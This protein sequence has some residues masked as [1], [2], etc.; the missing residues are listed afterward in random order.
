MMTDNAMMVTAITAQ[1]NSKG[2][3]SIFV[4]SKYSFSL[5]ES[6]LLE[7]KLAIGLELDEARLKELR[8]LSADDKTYG[9]AVRYAALRPRSEWEIQQYLQRKKAGPELCEKILNKLRK[10]DFVNDKVFASR[11]IENRRQLKPTST[12]KLQQELRAKHVADN[13]IS[14]SLAEDE[15]SEQQELQKLIA[16]KRQIPRYQDNQKLMQ[17]LARQGFSYDAIKSSL[18]DNE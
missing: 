13:I 1:V 6:A 5:G 18:K 14:Q 12:R 11:W 7:S 3:Y 10:L 8:Q 17:Y 16:K 9:L 15:G 2:R 4:D